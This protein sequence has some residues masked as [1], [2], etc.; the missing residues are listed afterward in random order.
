[1]DITYSSSITVKLSIFNFL[2]EYNLM[3]FHFDVCFY[4]KIA[5]AI[6][7]SLLPVCLFHVIWQLA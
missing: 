1:M 5:A 3:N 7:S 4:K 6:L 2:K